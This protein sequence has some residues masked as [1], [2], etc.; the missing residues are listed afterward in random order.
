[1]KSAWMT[2]DRTESGPTKRCPR[3]WVSDL[4]DSEKVREEGDDRPADGGFFA[5]RGVA[6][7]SETPEERE[8]RK[9][10][11]QKHRL[12]LPKRCMQ[13]HHTVDK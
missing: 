8:R 1:M 3:A 5:K 6:N 4:V 13:T 7:A 12:V 10:E 2:D 9:A 11:T